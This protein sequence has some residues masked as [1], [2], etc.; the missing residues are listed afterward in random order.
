[1]PIF[2]QAGWRLP[3]RFEETF[4]GGFENKHEWELETYL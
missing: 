1:M 4:S 3:A 2:S